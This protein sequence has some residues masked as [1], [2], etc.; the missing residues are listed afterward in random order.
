MASDATITFFH[1]ENDPVFPPS[2]VRPLAA[3]LEAK[4][5]VLPGQ[6][7]MTLLSRADLMDRVDRLFAGQG[8]RCGGPQ[9]GE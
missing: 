2:Q 7:H 4:L 9:D 6:G 5:C 8:D 1:G 3:R